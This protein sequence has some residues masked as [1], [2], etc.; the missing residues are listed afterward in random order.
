MDAYALLAGILFCP[1]AGSLSK[2]PTR[3]AQADP[4]PPDLFLTIGHRIVMFV[5]A[6][7]LWQLLSCLLATIFVG[8]VSAR[9]RPLYSS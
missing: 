6:L 8:I 9:H 5:M 4:P 1:F 3:G 2:T 7:Y